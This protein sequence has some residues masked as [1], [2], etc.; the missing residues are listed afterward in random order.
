MA[1]NKITLNVLADITRKL[2]GKGNFDSTSKALVVFTGS[3]IDLGEIK[4][5]S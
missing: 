2:N 4:L 3:N 5:K 1:K